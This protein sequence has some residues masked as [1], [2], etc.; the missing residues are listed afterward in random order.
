VQLLSDR[1]A[2]EHHGRHAVVYLID[3]H[4]IANAF[5]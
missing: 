3:G 5:N 2:S 1:N 4:R